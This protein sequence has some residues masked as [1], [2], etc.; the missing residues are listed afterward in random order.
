MAKNNNIQIKSCS[1]KI[2]L[3][4]DYSPRNKL[5]LRVKGKIKTDIANCK[6][7]LNF[8]P[9]KVVREPYNTT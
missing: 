4:L 7:K 5:S 3:D 6:V 9:N 2:R 8:H 1:N